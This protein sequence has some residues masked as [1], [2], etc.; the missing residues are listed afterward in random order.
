M[1]NVVAYLIKQKFAKKNFSDDEL[2]L[3]YTKMKPLTRVS[4]ATKEQHIKDVKS[5]K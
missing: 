5:K 4:K 1:N 2:K 3:L